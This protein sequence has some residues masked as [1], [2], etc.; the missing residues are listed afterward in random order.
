VELALGQANPGQ[1]TTSRY[2]GL[3]AP[4]PDEVDDGVACIVGNPTAL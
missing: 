4:V 3:V 1:G 2:P